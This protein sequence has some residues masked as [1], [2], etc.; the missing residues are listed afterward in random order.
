MRARAMRGVFRELWA[1]ALIAALG[2][3]Q[4][5]AESRTLPERERADQILES[6]GIKGGLVVHL[7]CGDGKLTAALCR[8]ESYLVHGLDADAENVERARRYIRSLGLYG[9]VSV[10]RWNAKRL[11]YIDNLVNLVVSERAPTVPIEEVLRVLVPNG[12]AYVKK[13]DRWTKTVKPRPKQMDEWTHYL[14]DPSNNAVAHDSLVQPPKHLQWVAGLQWSRHHDHMSSSSAMVSAHGRNFYI[15]DEGARSSILVPSDWQLIARD[16]FNGVLL[17]KRPISSWH[18]RLW[19]LKSGPAQLPRRLVAVGETVY[20]SLGLDT[21]VTALH[22]ASGETLH[23]YDNTR[24]TEEILFHDGVLFV[25]VNENP[26]EITGVPRKEDY[27]FGASPRRIVAVR[28]TTG[29]VLWDKRWRWVVPLTLTVDSQRVLF[30]DG[31]KVIALHRRTG[32]KLWESEML[33]RRASVPSYYGANLVVYDG[34]VLFAGVDPASI[35]EYHTDNAQTMWAFDAATG[36]TLWTAEHPQSGYRSPEDI[37]VIDGLV[38]TAPLFNS[39]DTGIFTGRDVRTGEVKAQFPP[40]VKTHWFHHRCYRAKATDQYILTSRTGIEFVDWKAQHWTC[41]HWVRGACLLGIMPANGMIY[42]APHPCACYLEAKLY[43]F[44]ALAPQRQSRPNSDSSER[45]ERGPAYDSVADLKSEIA[46][47]NDWPT[48]RH[49]TERSGYTKTTVPAEL[50]QAWENRLGGK[51]STLTVAEGKVFVAQVDTHTVHA[52][53]AGT[54]KALWSYTAGGRIDSPP[55]VWRRRVLFGSADGFVY[56]LGATDGA[57]AWRFRAAPGDERL[58]AFE[59]LESVWPLHGSVLVRD[60]IAW[61][62]AGRSM[63]LDKGIRLLRLDAATG[64]MLSET[65]MDDRDPA[66]GENLQLLLKG[67]NMPVAMPD[68]LSSDGKHVFMRSQRFD[69]Q[70]QRLQLE[71][72]TLDVKQQKGEGAHLFCPTGFLDDAY[73]HRSYWV[74]GQRWASGAGGYFLAGRYAPS[75]RLLVF[76]DATVYGFS[77]KPQYFRWTTP[78]ERQLFASSKEP[79]VIVNKPRQA[80]RA[81]QKSGA[82]TPPVARIAWQWSQSIPLHV[83]AMV[84]ANEKLFVAGP[85]DVLDEQATLRDFADPAVQKALAEQEAALNGERGT[86]LWVVSATNGEKLA[87]YKLHALPVWDGMVAASGKLFM[88]KTDGTIVSFGTN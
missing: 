14:H 28:A 44:N 37:L 26:P 2:Q 52:L 85:P 83:R 56:C 60:G 42:N 30:C 55:T 47:P 43:G 27:E 12:V 66:S 38:W 87:E 10:E 73:W 74:Y 81:K 5:A 67:L 63:F 75:G 31:E 34:I 59:Q 80:A 3:V 50:T 82:A 21:P 33:G 48:Y 29:E 49:D 39:S 76:D 24:G 32:E 58:I 7:N 86:L 84:L 54:G 62:V 13:G 69:S 22:A 77:R 79:E 35:T 18:N 23:T 53:D 25:V 9:K 72:P 20:V 65:V 6:A 8:N 71:T 11:P 40:D 78:I 46:N 88:A 36:K 16:A 41:H 64:R 70:G 17:W 51:L 61:C 45:L 1:A 19:R 57:L 68:I 4:S 15:F